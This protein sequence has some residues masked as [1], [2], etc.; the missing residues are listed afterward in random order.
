M[1][2]KRFIANS[3][4]EAMPLIIEQLGPNAVIVETREIRAAGMK[5]LF[6]KKQFEV[7]AVAHPMQAMEHDLTQTIVRKP[8][9]R[10]SNGSDDLN[11]QSQMIAGVW[12]LTDPTLLHPQHNQVSLTESELADEIRRMKQ[13]MMQSTSRKIVEPW[14]KPFDLLEQHLIAQ[15]VEKTVR[16]YIIFETRQI[17]ENQPFSELSR[18]QVW[19]AARLVIRNMMNTLAPTK[20]D[21]LAR[22]S[23]FVGQS[24]VGKTTTLAKIAAMQAVKYR[25]TVGLITSD[26]YRISS[27]DQLRIY[28]N[29][30]NIPM[31]VVFTPKELPRT[32]RKLAHCDVIF[33]D[34][35]C[36]SPH[37]DDFLTE[38]FR[39]FGAGEHTPIHLCISL[40]SEYTEVIPT[41]EK[42]LKFGVSRVFYTKEDVSS[43]VG[44]IINLAFQ[45]RLYPSF[46]TFGA[47]VP[48]DIRDFDLETYLDQLL[49]TSPSN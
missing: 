23:C 16:S 22:V 44:T 49:G 19:Q 1:N 14:P 9:A 48:D 21:E 35:A 24:G 7:F 39:F 11:S 29:Q 34:T 4:E 36:Q 20:G 32:L 25:R 8:F 13:W 5:R 12:S 45:Y 41:I 47:N 43:K 33:M 26:A 3:I 38:L 30:W 10:S 6:Q 2:V 37:I 18:E 46:I 31:E 15:Q 17:Y 27:V 42:F 28:A 40:T